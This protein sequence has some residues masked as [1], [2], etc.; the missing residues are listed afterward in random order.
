MN[1]PLSYLDPT[2][3]AK[4]KV[5]AGITPV[6]VGGDSIGGAIVAETAPPQFAAPGQ[7]TLAKGEVGAFFHSNNNAQGGNLSATLATENISISYTG[8]MAKADNYKAGGDFKRWTSTGR[9]GHTLALDEVGSTAYESR[10]HTLGFA[11]AAATTW[12]KPSSAIRTCLISSTPTSAWTCSTTSRSASTCATSASTTGACSKP[13]LT[14]NKLITSWISGLTS[15]IGME[16]I[17]VR[18]RAQNGTPCSPVGTS[19]AAGMPMY[20]ASKTT[21]INLKADVDLGTNDLLRIGALYQHYTLNDWWPASGG[22]MMPEYLREHQ[23]WQARPPGRLCR[24]GATYRQAMDDFGRR[25]LRA[26]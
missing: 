21:G 4:I 3:V 10:T 5:F 20:S 24:M 13:G 1:P 19:C 2:N 25:P 16:R 6:S 23:R 14:M 17:R 12:S 8:A 15:G 22:G 7:G 9:I 11:C 26:R 18:W